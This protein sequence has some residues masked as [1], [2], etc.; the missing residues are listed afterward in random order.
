MANLSLP[1]LEFKITADG[2]AAIEEIERA[3]EAA[4]SASRGASGAAG[5]FDSMGNAARRAGSEVQSAGKGAEEFGKKAESA[6]KKASVSMKDVGEKMSSIGKSMTAAITV[7]VVGA[8]AASVKGASD[9]TETLGKTDVVFGDMTD[10]VLEWSNSSVSAMGL[11]QQTALDMAATYGDMAT[12]MGLSRAEAANMS[13]ALVQLGADMEYYALRRAFRKLRQG[14]PA[15]HADATRR[16]EVPPHGGKGGFRRIGLGI[17]TGDSLSSAMLCIADVASR[18]GRLP[19]AQEDRGS[20][21]R[22]PLSPW[23]PPSP[24]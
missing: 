2:T 18:Q 8:L 4:E 14:R 24:S 5:G 21:K 17:S 12:G 1:E 7:P 22:S 15:G 10:R 16:R 13:T 3:E 11:A 23:I 19:A 20:V 6:A 9:M